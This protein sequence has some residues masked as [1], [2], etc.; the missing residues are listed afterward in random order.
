IQA[1]PRGDSASVNEILSTQ[2]GFVYDALGQIYVRGNHGSVQYQIDGVP[3]PDSVSGLFGQFLSPKLVEN[4]EVLSGGLPAE[5]G[6]RLSGVVNLNSR[7][8]SPSGEGEAELRYGSF[9]TWNPSA[10][11]G[12]KLGKV[13]FLAGGSF[14]YTERGLDPPNPDVLVNDQSKQGRFFRKADVALGRRGPFPPP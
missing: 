7:R 13:S 8:P 2:P 1:L 14:T 11:Y 12:Q 5:Y 4:M 10:F 3:L 9:N 6:Q